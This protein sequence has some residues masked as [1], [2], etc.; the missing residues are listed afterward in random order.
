MDLE[1]RFKKT[2]GAEVKPM[3]TIARNWG[4]GIGVRIPKK[5]AEK[6]GVSDG[7]RVNFEESDEGGI[8][9]LPIKNRPTLEDLVKNCTP[10]SAHDEIDFGGPSGREL[11]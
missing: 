2:E 1:K 7:V 3:T 4:N 11:I 8:V 6:Y 9:M 10:E 5:L